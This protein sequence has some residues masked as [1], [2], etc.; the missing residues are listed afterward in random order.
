MDAAVG[1]EDNDEGKVEDCGIEKS[2]S[3]LSSPKQIAN[4]VVYKL[5]RVEG[6]GRLVPATDDEVIRVED[7]LEDENSEMHVVADTGQSVGCISI[8]RSSSGRLRVE[9]S[10]GV[11]QSDTAESDLG[12][13]NARLQMLQEVKQEEKLRLACGS[14]GHFYVNTDIQC[15]ADKFPV[16]DGM[17]QSDISRQEV[18]PSLAPSVNDS[19]SNQSVSIGQCSRPS[20]GLVESG[21]STSA[22]YSTFCPDFSMLKEEICLDKLSIRELH[23][24]FKVTFGRE[25]TV[26]DKQWLKRR[27][28]MSLTNSCDVSTT[29]FIVRDNKLVKK[30]EKESCGNANAVLSVDA[31][32]GEMDVNSKDPLPAEGS[33]IDDNQAVSGKRLRNHDMEPELGN[34]DLQTGEKAAKRVRKPTKR[35]IEEL[36]ENEPRDHNQRFLSSN[37]NTGIGHFAP[38]SYMRPS[39]N[40][41][42]EGRTVFTRLDSLGGSGIQVP[43]VS[44]VRRSRPRKNIMSLMVHP[45]GTGNAIKL[46]DKALGVHGSQAD[47]ESRDETLTTPAEC[48]QPSFTESGQD[49]QCPILPTIELRQEFRL[50]KADPTT[51]ISD[52]K[53]VTVPTSKGGMRRK[54][55]RAWT[56]VEVMKLVEGVSRC[57]AGRWS[58]IKRLAFASYSYRTS[59]DLKDKWRNLL[60]ASFAQAPAD[61]GINSRKHGTVPIPEQILVRVRELA[62]LN[63]QVP[64]NLSSSKLTEGARSMRE[65]KS[66]GYL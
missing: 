20:E 54:H 5:V 42:S 2:S 44:R 62:E 55:H 15:S 7:F 17:I 33:G 3:V 56:L 25:T 61:E 37:K 10:K 24:L 53:M 11:S 32:A 57:G 59:V 64:P 52:D 13:L 19:H 45:C 31:T 21:S 23:E 6:D 30:C 41:F 43:C 22:V 49:E 27:I 60:K 48:Q 63:S 4:P 36:S 14:P 46:V 18:V 12:K 38:N 40:M 28:A 26:K 50:K 47:S 1:I 29:T 39:R 16:A 51:H 35:Y 65:D 34:K 9:C 66:A 8:E 58:E